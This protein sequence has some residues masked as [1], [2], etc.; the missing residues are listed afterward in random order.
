MGGDGREGMA[1]ALLAAREL[2]QGLSPRCHEPGCPH[3]R[4]FWQRARHRGKQ[5]V[6]QGERY[7]AD[8]CLDRALRSAL[9]EA[10]RLP[11][12]RVV[13]HRIPMGLL[14]VS[15]QQLSSGQL[16]AALEAQQAAGRGR[17]GEWLQSLGYATEAEV[18]AALARQW[19][20]P[21]LRGQRL[22]IRTASAPPL[23][24][25]LMRWL[26]MAPVDFVEA[27]RTLHVAFADGLDY[28]VLFALEQMLQCRTEPC[29]V[30]P[31]VLERYFEQL[32]ES[33]EESEV[34]FERVH[35]IAEFAR[36]IRSYAARLTVSEIRLVPCASHI[37][38][39]LMR[40]ARTPTDLIARGI[41]DV[42]HISELRPAVP[43]AMAV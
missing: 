5:M 43:G 40:E 13:H 28:T 22:G 20:C 32:G 39:R 2:W 11:P 29:L 10:C 24:M 18:T 8:S 33:R 36:I 34:L 6:L 4:N 21:V 19:S 31:S 3:N 35:D 27:T 38:V 17:I 1:S 41:R 14:M 12:H 15:R 37:W 25:T 16:R 23:P 9:G 7:C 26:A 42:A 30:R